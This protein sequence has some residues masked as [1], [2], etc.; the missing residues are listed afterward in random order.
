MKKLMIL[1][2]III[3]STQLLGC[4]SPTENRYDLIALENNSNIGASAGGIFFIWSATIK[5]EIYYYA[6]VRDSTGATSLIKLPYKNIFFYEDVNIEKPYAVSICNET[7]LADIYD[8]KFHIPPNSIKQNIDIDLAN[9]K[10]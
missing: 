4:E 1:I 5:E 10:K 2:L 3:L 6:Y 8:W 7:K 9:I